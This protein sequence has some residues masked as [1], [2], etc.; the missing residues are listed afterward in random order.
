[1]NSKNIVLVL[2][3]PCAGKTTISKMISKVLKCAHISIGDLIRKARDNSQT[4]SINTDGAFKG[5]EM[6][7]PQFIK[8]LL[9][10]NPAFIGNDFIVIDAGPPIESVL[11]DLNADVLCVI[12]IKTGDKLRYER[13]LVRQKTGIR[14]DDLESLFKDR[15]IHYKNNLISTLQYF[16]KR[17]ILFEMDGGYSITQMLK[18]ALSIV[19]LSLT[20]EN[21]YGNVRDFEVV[22]SHPWYEILKNKYSQY[23]LNSSIFVNE[24][25]YSKDADYNQMVMLLK[26]GLHF[27][28]SV[29]TY[30]SD[31]LRKLGYEIGAINIVN[32]SLIK[33]YSI[34]KAHF[35]LHYIY[36]RYAQDVV[37]PM[38]NINERKIRVLGSYDFCDLY[39]NKGLDKIWNDSNNM[40]LKEGQSLWIKTEDKTTIINGHIPSIIN[41]YEDDKN[42]IIALH[43][44]QYRPNAANWS[45]MREVYLGETNPIKAK[46][47]SLR[48]LAYNGELE[49]Q[50]DITFQNNAFHMSSGPLE[51]F[52]EMM[53]WFGKNYAMAKSECVFSK[54][55]NFNNALFN[56][57]NLTRE[58]DNYSL[59]LNTDMKDLNKFVARRGKK[60]GM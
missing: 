58:M 37:S 33:K 10:S 26:P 4:I 35:D 20:A 15:S 17:D 9:T 29:L 38:L 48:G 32:G 59:T 6:Y 51:G 50:G 39:G 24:S 30:L 52:R 53:I 28:D 46:P 55:L 36:A 16:K 34:A 44:K 2:G 11:P 3:M 13:F 1:M 54:D 42:T 43:I 19:Y 45:Y 22:K 40:P 14:N 8:N 31:S 57:F 56:Q 5:K 23:E 27:S 25:S 7:N 47:D 18:Q 60:W 41:Q 49:I 12:N 21:T